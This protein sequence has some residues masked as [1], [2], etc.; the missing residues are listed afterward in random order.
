MSVNDTIEK[1]SVCTYCGVGCDIT[2]VITN[3]KIDKIYAQAN[4]YVSRGKLCIKGSRGYDFVHSD[5][6]VRDIRIKKSFI[7]KVF[8]DMP[9]DLKARKNTLKSYNDEWY[10]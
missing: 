4:G 6:R 5:S 3:N 7:S 2:A 1:G 9:R 10:T 8:E